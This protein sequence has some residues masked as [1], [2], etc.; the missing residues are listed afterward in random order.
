MVL[1]LRL[2]G[3]LRLGF[4][5]RP[6]DLFWHI[7]AIVRRV[8]NGWRLYHKIV[9]QTPPERVSPAIRRANI[10]SGEMPTTRKEDTGGTTNTLYCRVHER[11]LEPHD[12]SSQDRT[13]GQCAERAHRP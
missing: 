12:G 11:L 8:V 9:R 13:D 2:T 3:A 7:A 5:D 6:N 1:G 10:R 4:D